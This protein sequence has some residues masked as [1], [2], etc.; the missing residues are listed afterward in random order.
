MYV[1]GP[2]VLTIPRLVTRL[3]VIAALGL[4]ATVPLIVTTVAQDD[5]DDSPE[6]AFQTELLVDGLTAPVQLVHAN[7]GSGRMFIV[8]KGGQVLVLKDGEVL[9]EP[10]LDISGQISTGSE[11][12][13]LSIALHPDF[14]ENGAF[15]IDYTDNEGNSQIERWQISAD[16]PDRADP[17]STVML[18]SVDQPYANHNG[19]LL[20][21]GPDGYLYIGFGDGGSGGDPEG[22]AQNLGTLLGKILRIDVDGTEEDLPYAI[23]DDNPFL[24]RDD[25]RSEIWA[26]GLRNPW[27]FSFDRDT[28][29]LYIGDVGQNAIEEADLAPAGQGGLNFGWVILEGPTCFLEE[30]CDQTGLTPPFFWYNQDDGGCSITGG[31]VYRGEA[32][33]DLTGAYLVGDY[34]SGYLWVV[35][36]ESGEASAPIETEIS[37][38]SFAEDADGELYLV[39][40]GGAIYKIVP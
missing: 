30:D 4:L 34:C 12:G 5:G 13:L 21:F 24:D 33:P 10:L 22:N 23:P 26:Y 37:I 27:R 39:D 20:L 25:A 1:G 38:S 16:N 9:P 11:Q 7:D 40:L 15:F 6:F 14:A 29:D 8:Q 19:G 31:Y 18:L 2:N 36:P 17:E 3:L 32:I 28:G 35:D